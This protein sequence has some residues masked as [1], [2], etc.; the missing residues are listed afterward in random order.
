MPS[1]FQKLLLR[2]TGL[3]RF[4]DEWTELRAEVFALKS[5]LL[6]Q[7]MVLCE[8]ARRPE[9]P[10]RELAAPR[11]VA[12]EEL[13]HR[14]EQAAPDAFR[15]WRGLMDTNARAYEGTP[16]H[17]CS[18]AGHPMAELFGFFLRPY[19]RG[20]V[21]DVGC[22][23]QPTPSYLEGYPRNLVSGL[24]PLSKPEDHPF[25][26]VQGLA[27]FLPWA[28][29][30]F[31]VVIAATSLDHVLLL[32]K[33]LQEIKR[34]LAPDGVF[35]VWVGYVRGAA[36]Y[37]TWALPVRA[38]DQY[39]LFHFDRDWFLEFIQKELTVLEHIS[40][41]PNDCSAFISLAKR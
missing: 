33:S 10:P 39:H 36:R 11:H 31:D 4:R 3:A 9:A 6:R 26:F 20:Y 35:V 18:V 22:G 34:V 30:Q 1:R 29:G 24:D 23:P 38:V 37:D 41:A 17:S 32:E 19:L 14:L 7:R 40:F 5:E 25:V 13:Y 12:M 28:D 2:A 21:L 16:I 15:I 27:E 8:R